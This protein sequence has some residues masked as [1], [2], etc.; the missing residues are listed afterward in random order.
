MKYVYALTVY[1]VLRTDDV[2]GTLLGPLLGVSR[3]CCIRRNFMLCLLLHDFVQHSVC[4]QKIAF[5]RSGMR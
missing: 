2:A 1:H 4:P 3:V 5:A